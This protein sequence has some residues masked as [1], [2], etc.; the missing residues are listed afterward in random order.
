MRRVLHVGCGG[1]RLPPWLDGEETRLDIDERH[2]PDIVA[3]LTDMSPVEDGSFDVVFTSH[4]LEHVYPH[5]VPVALSECLRVL[6]DGGALIVFVPNLEG[7]KADETVLYQSPAGPITG[8]D[9][10]YGAR[11]LIKDMPFMAHHT[12]F[13]PSTLTQ[14]FVDAG[15]SQVRI[16]VLEQY[17]LMGVGVK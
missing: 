3:S 17:N 11:W 1:E 12:G 9:M 4:T 16:K 10:I 7:V 13:V 8:L 6:K 14:A 15:F 2:S 5:E